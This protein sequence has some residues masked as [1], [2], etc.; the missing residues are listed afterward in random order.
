M[1]VTRIPFSARVRFIDSNERTVQTLSRLRPNLMPM[2]LDSLRIVMNNIRD[3]DYPT[4]GGFY[5]VTD[6]L[7]QA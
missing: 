5:T 3:E 4:I 1:A 6:E 7:R 2:Q